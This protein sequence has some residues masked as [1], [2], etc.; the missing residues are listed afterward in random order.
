MIA[1]VVLGLIAGL[2]AGNALPHFLK[3][4]QME[5]YPSVLGNSPVPNFIAGWTGLAVSVGFFLWGSAFA[6]TIELVGFGLIGVLIAGVLHA[7]YGAFGKKQGA[8]TD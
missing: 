4:I 5:D 2:S 7:R 1:A 6:A 3:G 8:G